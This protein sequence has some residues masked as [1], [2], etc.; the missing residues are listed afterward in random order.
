MKRQ[1]TAAWETIQ[2]L[3]NCTLQKYQLLAFVSPDVFTN[4]FLTITKGF[5]RLPN[6]S[7]VDPNMFEV[8]PKYSAYGQRTSKS[9][10]NGHTSC[11]FMRD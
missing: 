3:P 11:S 4:Y 9:I 10:L 6:D 7:E 2:L 5:W 1:I 8:N